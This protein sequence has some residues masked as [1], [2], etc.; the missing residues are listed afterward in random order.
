MDITPT[1]MYDCSYLF[2]CSL[3]R[4]ILC[5]FYIII[6]KYKIVYYICKK[7]VFT[8]RIKILQYGKLGDLRFTGSILDMYLGKLGIIHETAVYVK[9]IC[10]SPSNN[11]FTLLGMVN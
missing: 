9:K 4:Y 1:K 6:S 7:L 3:D 11:D 10:P 2:N 8:K 5:Y